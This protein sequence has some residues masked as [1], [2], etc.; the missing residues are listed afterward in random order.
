MVDRTRNLK[1]PPIFFFPTFHSLFLEKMELQCLYMHL[2]CVN[3]TPHDGLPNPLHVWTILDYKVW[4]KVGL[5]INL[6]SNDGSSFS[7]FKTI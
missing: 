3:G 4:T 5:L 7:F 6:Q 2:S 1:V